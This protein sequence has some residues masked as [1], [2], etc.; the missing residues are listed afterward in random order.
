MTTIPAQ[1]ARLWLVI[2]WMALAVLL[3][4]GTW[5]SA[6]AVVPALTAEGG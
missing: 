5:F 1:P 2:L 3:A 4:K 6:S